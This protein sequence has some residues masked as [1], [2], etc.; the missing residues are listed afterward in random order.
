MTTILDLNAAVATTEDWIDDLMRRLGWQKL[1]NLRSQYDVKENK[2]I[3]RDRNFATVISEINGDEGNFVLAFNS[4]LAQVLSTEF[5]IFYKSYYDS[6]PWYAKPI[7]LAGLSLIAL[8]ACL[9][10]YVFLPRQAKTP[11]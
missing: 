7:I 2:M 8:L 10:C 4:E 3:I 11:T 5:T 6:V 9:V 1:A